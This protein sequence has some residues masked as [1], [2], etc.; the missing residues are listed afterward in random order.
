MPPIALRRFLES[1]AVAGNP[2]SCCTTA[3]PRP[4]IGEPHGEAASSQSAEFRPALLMG[5]GEGPAKQW[6]QR[7]LAHGGQETNVYWTDKQNPNST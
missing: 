6:S 3:L 5:L 4:R 1:E 2:D 7:A